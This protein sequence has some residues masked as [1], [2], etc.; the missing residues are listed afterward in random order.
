[1]K[2]DKNEENV[3]EF[4]AAYEIEKT[5]RGEENEFWGDNITE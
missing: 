5:M 3:H 2:Q 4:S 1:M